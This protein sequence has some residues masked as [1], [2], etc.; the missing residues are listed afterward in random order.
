MPKLSRHIP[1]FVQVQEK[2]SQS[3]LCLSNHNLPSS[4]YNKSSDSNSMVTRDTISVM[5]RTPSPMGE[6]ADIITEEKVQVIIDG[7]TNSDDSP[8]L[9]DTRRCSLDSVGKDG[10][11]DEEDHTIDNMGTTS[12]RRPSN[13]SQSLP[14]NSNNGIGG[15]G[16]GG[17]SSSSTEQLPKRWKPKGRSSKKST[18]LFASF[19]KKKNQIKN[20]S[21]HSS[22]PSSLTFLEEEEDGDTIRR[23]SDHSTG[24]TDI[25][26]D[27]GCKTAAEVSRL[28]NNNGRGRVDS[29][30]LSPHSSFT[31]TYSR[32][33]GDKE[34]LRGSFVSQRSSSELIDNEFLDVAEFL[35]NSLDSKTMLENLGD[36]PSQHDLAN[37]AAVRAKE[38]IEECLSADV[39]VIDRT[40]W[41]SIPQFTKMDL[42]VGAHLGKGSFSDVFEV[43]TTIVEEEAPTLERLGS[44][45]ADL[46]KLVVAKFGNGGEKRG[47][48]SLKKNGDT[49]EGDDLDA[50]IDAMFGKQDKVDDAE[51]D[52]MFGNVTKNS[53]P[54]IQEEGDSLDAEIDAMFSVPK[55]KAKSG[56]VGSFRGSFTAPSPIAEDEEVTDEDEATS[57][58]VQPERRVKQRSVREG[59]APRRQTTDLGT[60]RSSF[61]IGTSARQT[62]QKRRERKVTL[63]MKC[64]RPQIR[65]DAEQFMIGVEDLVH[66]T[67]MLASL[68]HKHIVKLHGRAGG[69]VSNSFRL[70]DGFFILLD[71]LKDTLDERIVRWKNQGADKKGQPSMSQLKTAV[72]IAD[73]LSYLHTKRII[74]RDLKPANVGFD[75]TGVLKLFDFGFAVGIDESKGK[76]RDEDDEGEEAP[77]L[78]DKCGTPRYMASEVGLEQGYSLPADVYSYGIL[79]WEILALKKPFRNI[80][81]ASEFHKTVFEKGARPKVSKSWPQSLQEIMTTCWS[82]DPSERPTMAHTKTMIS[83][84]AR[85]ASN[86]QNNGNNNS[87]RKSVLRRFTG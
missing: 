4:N 80:K 58:N 81:S 66:E 7:L 50:E 30:D 37:I 3:T 33:G 77:L 46:D 1:P 79:L 8:S 17:S 29:D 84:Y 68:D 27:Q 73:A 28:I 76:S 70:S 53:A 26:N 36:E 12:T 43:F 78:F 40:K 60:L 67:A 31:S 65:S 47:D 10:D 83:A 59:R 25:I 39:K 32:G 72:S 48:S 56:S 61:C 6:L 51:I 63:A 54:A 62:S 64:L 15:G 20:F 49:N 24:L 74:F 11:V 85:E 14:A 2:M 22:H 45:R 34:S 23:N 18:G 75:S 55:P 69:C 5:T 19:S 21:N 16:G 41:E 35:A 13:L 86:N 82:A 52:A 44:D 9:S 42:V 71:R 57:R 87:M 38:Y